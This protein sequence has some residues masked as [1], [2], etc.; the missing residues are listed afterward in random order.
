[1]PS[2]EINCDMGEGCPTDGQV[3]PFLDCANVSCGTHAGSP[4]E[5]LNTLQ[6][7][8][9]YNVKVGAHPGYAD[10]ENFGRHSLHLSTDELYQSLQSQ[11]LFFNDLCATENIKIHY[12]KPHGALN[13]DMIA[14]TDILNT[15][16]QVVAKVFANT[17]LMIPTNEKQP[18]IIEIVSQYSLPIVWEIFADRAYENNGLL[19]NRKLPEAVHDSADKIISQYRQAKSAQTILSHD[20]TTLLDVSS[21][22]SICIHGDNPASIV[23]VKQFR[24]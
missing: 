6:L 12:V 16:C 2:L 14:N 19:R 5:I 17:A 4:S 3:M 8:K 15:I 23:A 24:Q 22:T 1:M 9:K 11:L 18:Q 10:R 13:H 7:A 21:A 20:Q